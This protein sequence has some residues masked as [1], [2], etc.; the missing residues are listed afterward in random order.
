MRLLRIASAIIP[1]YRGVAERSTRRERDE[2]WE[3]VG[4]KRHDRTMPAYDNYTS[5]GQLHPYTAVIRE[6][7]LVP[8]TWSCLAAQPDSVRLDSNRLR[9]D[10]W[11]TVCIKSWLTYAR[12][13][14]PNRGRYGSSVSWIFSRVIDELIK[15]LCLQVCKL[16]MQTTLS[17]L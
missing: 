10:G 4:R 16:N 7:F 15:H 1:L 9:R 12:C 6:P 5:T 8:P 11:I 17:G 3:T 2:E 13:I 14:L